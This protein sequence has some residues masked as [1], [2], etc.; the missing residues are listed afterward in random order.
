MSIK[1]LQGASV[2]QGAAMDSS[3]DACGAISPQ[4]SGSFYERRLKSING[5]TDAKTLALGLQSGVMLDL[6]AS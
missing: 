5:L 1:A 3:E 6:G 4:N 2:H